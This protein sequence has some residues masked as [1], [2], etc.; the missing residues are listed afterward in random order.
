MP[1]ISTP[2]ITDLRRKYGTQAS[3]HMD[4]QPDIVQ[5]LAK[6]IAPYFQL[7]PSDIFIP[8]R[9]RSI[10]DARQVLMFA[11]HRGCDLTLTETGRMAVLG[12]AD[13]TTVI[14]ACEIIGY[15]GRSVQRVADALDEAVRVAREYNKTLK[16]NSTQ[17]E[18]GLNQRLEKAVKYI[19]HSDG[20]S[21]LE[22]AKTLLL[23][24][25]LNYNTA[26]A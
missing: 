17:S 9:V 2:S 5:R 4:Q 22:T 14:H 20:L 13:H 3:D 6:V 21:D 7:Q 11:L 15:T 19:I 10:V 1:R 25:I 8:R 26:T 24:E 16:I 18:Y 12:G 23:E